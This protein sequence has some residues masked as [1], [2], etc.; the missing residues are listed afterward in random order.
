[1]MARNNYK[2]IIN[3]VYQMI[4]KYMALVKNFPVVANGTKLKQTIDN[5]TAQ[6]KMVCTRM[7]E[8]K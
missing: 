1:M 4:D 3:E 8:D 5:F 6:L 2:I 7:S